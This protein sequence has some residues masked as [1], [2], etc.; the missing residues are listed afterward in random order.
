M[1]LTRSLARCAL[2]LL[3]AALVQPSM[4][5]PVLDR[6]KSS[7]TVVIAHRE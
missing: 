6:I 5:G 1:P 3:A 4:A 7:G 2:A